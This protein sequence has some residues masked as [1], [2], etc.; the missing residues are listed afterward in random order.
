MYKIDNISIYDYFNLEDASSY[1]VFINTLKP[2]NSFNGRKCKVGNLTFDQIEVIKKIFSSPT[3]AD[4]KDMFQTCFDIRGSFEESAD[5]EFY[6]TSIFELFRAKRFLQD[7]IV[8]LIERE[9][10]QLS[11]AT[12]D[13]MLMINAG[14]RLRPFNHQLT[15][16][17]IAEQFSRTPKEIG[18]W[19]YREVFS[20]LVANKVNAEITKEY[21]EIK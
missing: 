1:D 8:T 21:Q 13:K 7:H 20:I 18:N 14:E 6:N 10:N 3:I 16:M 4:I 12:D 19:K 17:R 2:V 15:K 9:K 11:G 5:Y